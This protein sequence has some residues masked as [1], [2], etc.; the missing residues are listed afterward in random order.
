VQVLLAA[1]ADVEV[2]D[3]N[4]RT[5]VMYA[6]RNGRKEVVQVLLAAGADVE[7]KDNDGWTALM[8]ASLRGL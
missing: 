7:V 1:G 6:S 3:N 2:K 5:S 4:G 8:W